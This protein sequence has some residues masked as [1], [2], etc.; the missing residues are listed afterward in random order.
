MSNPAIILVRPQMGENIGMVAR[1]ML[2]CGLTDLRLVSPRDGWPSD[3]ASR[4]ASGALEQGVRVS[5]YEDTKNAIADCHLTFAT[6]ARPR[7]MV[8]EVFT[9]QGAMQKAHELI[10]NGQTI[11]VLFGG[12]RA[13]LANE[14]IA[15][16]SAIITVPLN[17]DFTSL[18]LAQAVLLVAYDYLRL[19]DTTK[20]NQLV[21]GKTDLAT[22]ETTDQFT[23]RLI[24]LL[25][26]HGFFRSDDL[27]P[28]TERNLSNLFHRLPLTDQ[29]IQTFHG[30]LSA[31]TKK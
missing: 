27:R 3:V 8:K 11:G 21:M 19:A 10:P 12:E 23:R 9:A 14:D 4:A 18:N 7:E 24:G 13:G 26:E 22:H 1:A 16:A 20:G 15:L 31:L 25:D 2:N 29:D 5:V 6:T 30:I 17:P 28:T